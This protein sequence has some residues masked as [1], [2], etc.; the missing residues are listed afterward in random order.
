[1]NFFRLSLVGIAL[2]AISAYAHVKSGSLL[3]AG[4]ETFQTGATM[5][6]EWT[7]TQAHDGRYDIYFSKDG[8]KTYPL[9]MAGPWQGSRTDGAKNTYLWKIPDDAVTTQGR[10]RICQLF[11]GHCVQ[12]NVYMLDS[13]ANFTISSQPVALQPEKAVKDAAVSFALVADQ[14]KL[15]LRFTLAEKQ[16]ISIKAFDV[17]GNLVATVAQG[18]F[19]QGEHQIKALEAASQHKGPLVF[20]LDLGKN[21]TV[22]Q[23]WNGF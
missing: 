18:E 13:P 22:S 5:T 3:P 14:S 23:M 8:G 1:M 9:E 4:G 15:D 2:G 12:P 21:G 10:I 6:I 11:G 20:T 7:A 19:A 17:S 16:N